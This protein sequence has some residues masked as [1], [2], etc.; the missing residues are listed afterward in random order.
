MT[1]QRELDHMYVGLQ[2]WEQKEHQQYM[3]GGLVM[4]CRS[5]SFWR[6]G[7][8]TELPKTQ[9]ITKSAQALS[10]G[11]QQVLTRNKVRLSCAVPVP[12]PLP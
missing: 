7:I 8:S 9:T 12:V 2:P 10:C 6:G 1:T 3:G 11:S 4:R 5:H